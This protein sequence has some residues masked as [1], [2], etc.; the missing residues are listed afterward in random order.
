[1]Q[2]KKK[3]PPE[4]HVHD[5][6]MWDCEDPLPPKDKGRG[7]WCVYKHLSPEGKYYIG[8]T[9]QK[10]E[11]RWHNG[12]GYKKNKAFYEDIRRLGWDSFSHSI[13]LQ[14]VTLLEALTAEYFNIMFFDGVHSDDC[15]NRVSIG[16]G[17]YDAGR[18]AK[19]SE[20]LKNYAKEHPERFRGLR[21]YSRD[22]MQ[23]PVRCIETG[24]V[25]SGVREAARQLNLNFRAISNVCNG[26]RKTHDGYHWEYLQ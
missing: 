3:A 10:P 13:L 6:R 7:P 11:K 1:M 23:K 24:V 5:F 2:K 9:R 12:E 22:K 4:L 21:D 14:G 18:N 20:T 26:R 15:Y 16:S 19:I 17:A 25:Y 8:I